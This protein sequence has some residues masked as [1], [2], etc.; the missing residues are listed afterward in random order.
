MPQHI[1]EWN[2]ASEGWHCPW[3]KNDLRVGGRFTSR[4]EERANKENGFDFGGTYSDVVLMKHIAY[5]MDGE[6][7]R[8][9]DISF[10]ETTNGVKVTETFETE[11]E[12]PMEMQRNGWQSIMDRFKKY[13][14][15]LLNR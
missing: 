6:D 8:T 10:E 2:A 4:M 12:N 15:D 13:T 9:V 1:Q 5:T 7:A 3:A 14:E 11:N